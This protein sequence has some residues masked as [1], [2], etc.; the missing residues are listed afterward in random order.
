MH[1]ADHRVPIT[2]DELITQLVQFRARYPQ[3]GARFVHLLNM[4]D[5]GDGL[6][7]AVDIDCFD[8][9]Q[10]LVI[11]LLSGPM[12]QPCPC[13]ALRRVPGGCCWR[14]EPPDPGCDPPVAIDSIS[15]ML[16]PQ[17]GRSEEPSQGTSARPQWRHACHYRGSLFGNYGR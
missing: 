14:G 4:D 9:Q 13:L 6:I 1:P 10:G 5:D 15:N 7:T 16:V 17:P 2:L 12:P 3:Q 11:S 8:P